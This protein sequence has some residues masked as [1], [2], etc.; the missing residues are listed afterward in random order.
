MPEYVMYYSFKENIS[1]SNSW[2]SCRV[3]QWLSTSKINII[4]KKKTCYK[5]QRT[6]EDG[7]NPEKALQKSNL[8]ENGWRGGWWWMKGG[9][10][11]SSEKNSRS[12]EQSSVVH[13]RLPSSPRTE[14]WFDEIQTEEKKKKGEKSLKPVYRFN[15]TERR[16]KWGWKGKRQREWRIFFFFLAETEWE[17]YSSRHSSYK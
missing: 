4:I 15:Y 12:Q 6:F 16:G 9:C 5:S 2:N 14:S 17:L 11:S 7:L 13:P 1:M 3:E 8:K 10:E